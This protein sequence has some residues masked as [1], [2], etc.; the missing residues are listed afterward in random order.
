MIFIVYND[1]NTYHTYITNRILVIMIEYIVLIHLLCYVY[2]KSP[3]NYRIC[4]IFIESFP[5]ARTNSNNLYGLSLVCSSNVSDLIILVIMSL[6][7]GCN[8]R[9]DRLSSL[10]SLTLRGVNR[11][12]L[13][14]NHTTISFTS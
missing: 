14:F 13:E 6:F 7:L 9:D 2:C 8:T 5:I 1:V 4:F 11:L 10:I 3:I 12:I